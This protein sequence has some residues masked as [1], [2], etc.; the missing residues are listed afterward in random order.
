MEDNVNLARLIVNGL[1]FY[2]IEDGEA[3]LTEFQQRKVTAAIA[4]VAKHLETSPLGS[5]DITAYA[6]QDLRVSI[7][8]RKGRPWD[9][10]GLEGY[11]LLQE[12]GLMTP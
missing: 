1:T 8:E 2:R 3:D 11:L 9:I 6:M 12:S 5:Q 4:A 7:K 10:V